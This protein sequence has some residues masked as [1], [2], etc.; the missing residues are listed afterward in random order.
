MDRRALVIIGGV[1]VL[2]ILVLLV[3]PSLNPPTPTTPTVTDA[4]TQPPITETPQPPTPSP[5]P[6]A[7]SLTLEAAPNNTFIA[8]TWPP[9]E[10]AAGY[11]L[12]RDGAERP[13]NA[14]LLSDTRY[15]DIGLTNGRTYRYQVVAVDADG[16]T[17]AQS[18]IVEAVPTSRP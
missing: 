9:V 1:V 16:A 5:S 18:E 4:P 10:G 8:L 6:A 17:L 12:F 14:E 7:A 2:A 11:Q 3:A 13:L 15:Q